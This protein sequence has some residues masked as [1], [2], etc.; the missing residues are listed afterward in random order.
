MLLK[1]AFNCYIRIPL[2]AYMHA[3]VLCDVLSRIC[4]VIAVEQSRRRRR[5]HPPPPT[6]SIFC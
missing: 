3:R 2:E 4:S 1:K 6:S 5:S